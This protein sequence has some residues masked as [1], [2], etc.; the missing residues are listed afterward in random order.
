MWKRLLTRNTL[1]WFVA[2]A[3]LLPLLIFAIDWYT[4]PVNRWQQRLDQ[5]QQGKMDYLEEFEE[6]RKFLRS[7]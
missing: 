5:Q 1:I 4:T 7:D 2:C 6:Q 3:L